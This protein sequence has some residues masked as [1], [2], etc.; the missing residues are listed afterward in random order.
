MSSTNLPSGIKHTHARAG[1]K[2]YFILQEIDVALDEGEFS[3]RKAISLRWVARNRWRIERGTGII[4]DKFDL[5][6]AASE[7]M[8][9]V[10]RAT[11]GFDGDASVPDTETVADPDR[12]FPSIEGMFFPLEDELP[13]V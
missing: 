1:A 8:P 2:D 5:G 10:Q 7:L 4:I 12:P 6:W 3:E 9:T 13:P 11:L